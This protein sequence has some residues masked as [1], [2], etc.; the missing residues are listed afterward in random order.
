MAAP[1]EPALVDPSEFDLSDATDSESFPVK[2]LQDCDDEDQTSDED[3]SV[4]LENFRGPDDDSVHKK[5]EIN[6]DSFD[7]EHQTSNG[8]QSQSPNDDI[9]NTTDGNGPEE[10]AHDNTENLNEK[11]GQGSESDSKPLAPVF[12]IYHKFG[13]FPGDSG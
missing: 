10:Q 7:K 13:T 12:P 5:D 3:D 8:S 2:G 11:E 4:D 9:I 6:P 1:A